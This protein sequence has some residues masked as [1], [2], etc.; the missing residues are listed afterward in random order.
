MSLVRSMNVKLKPTAGQDRRLHA[1]L[2]S[3]RHLYNAA[4]EER[5]GRWRH[6]GVSVTKFDQ[7]KELT[8]AHIEIPSLQRYGLSVHRGT[9]S[10]LGKAFDGFFRRVKTGET[11]GFPR[12]KSAN[13]FT[14]IQW[15]EPKGWEVYPTGNASY[16]RIYMMGVGHVKVKLPGRRF[17]GGERRTMT[18]RLTANGWVATIVYRNVLVPAVPESVRSL[19]V[20]RGVT[21]IAALVADDGA[22]ELVE[23][24]R[25]LNRA[26][27]NLAAKQQVLA[28]KQR[29]SNRRKKA[30]RDVARA[31]GKVRN[32]RTNRNHQLSR[33]LVDENQTIVLEKLQTA[34]M[35]RRPKPKPTEDGGFDPNGAAAKA[36]LNKAILD[37]AWG[38]LAAMIDY[39]A[40]EAGRQ[41]I[42]VNPRN[43]SQTCH[44]CGHVAGENRVGVVFRCLGCGHE[45]HA[46]LNAA[47]N[48]LVAGVPPASK[49]R[50]A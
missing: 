46:D 7:F 14:S 25:H 2:T 35:V 24:P 47:R 6:D 48:I 37:A 31:Q 28:R 10:R 1:L 17:S 3:Q 49:R 20:D 33:R 15:D 45:D 29:G 23:N 13:R 34:N 8:G 16:G 42:Y 27:E 50:V 30:V 4:L 11:P 44:A 22:T 39:K 19:G 32:A 41:V 40:A 21:V 18:V 9:L 5:I 26:A 38:Q 12:F 43:T 36:G